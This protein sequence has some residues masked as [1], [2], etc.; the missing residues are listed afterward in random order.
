MHSWLSLLFCKNKVN[1]IEIYSSKSPALPDPNEPET[2]SDTVAKW[3][4]DYIVITQVDRDDM[5][6]GGASHFAKTIGLV[7]K[8]SPKMY[9]KI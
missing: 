9:V 2:C 8:K 3:N 5:P 1:K 4:I 7:K 6:D